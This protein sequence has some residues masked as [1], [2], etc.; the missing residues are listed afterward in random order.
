MKNLT[1]RVAKLV[2]T[3]T[4]S[5]W[6]QIHTFFPDDL[7]KRHKRGILLAVLSFSGAGE[8]VEAMAFGR[9][10]LSR[11]HEEYYGKEEVSVM[12]G[13]VQAVE[14]V[15][16]EFSG[17][18]R[19]LEITAGVILGDI[20]YLAIFGP[21]QV[22]VKRENT[23]Q[24][25]LVGSGEKTENASGFIKTQDIIILGTGSFFDLLPQGVL[26]AALDG[27]GPEQIAETLAPEVVGREQTAMVASLIGRIEEELPIG[28]ELPKEE[29]QEFP[30]PEE[31]LVV[32]KPSYGEKLRE[33]LR[34]MRVKLP[35]ID[36]KKFSSYFP[37]R[38]NAVSGEES[39]YLRR[40][41]KEVKTRK[42]IF[43]VA[44]ILVFLLIS[45]VIFGGRKKEDSG[46]QVQYS[47]L[48][49]EVNS[50]LE[51][52]QSLISLNPARAKELLLE[53]KEKFKQLEG[54]K[55]QNSQTE[56]LGKK[57]EEG[58]ELLSKEQVPTEVPIYLDL[59]LIKENTRGNKLSLHDNFLVVLDSTDNRVLGINL[60]KKS[61]EILAGGDV[62]AGAT[63]TAN[64]GD[65]VYVLVK[66]GIKKIGTKSKN[67]QLVIKSDPEWGRIIALGSFS[68][69]LYLLDAGKGTIWY[70]RPTGA[71]FSQKQKWF[72][73]PADITGVT[74]M[75]IDGSIWLLR[76]DGKIQK[77]SY[78]APLD[79]IVRGLDQALSGSTLIYV[80]E[81]TKNMYILDKGNK[82]TVILGKSGEYVSQY[83][84]GGLASISDFA[85]S[86]KLKK[87][88]LLQENKIFTIDLK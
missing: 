77:F 75:K 81:E 6:S 4:S 38:R 52:G 58:L 88:F 71:G 34:G 1:A 33:F 48:L 12:N 26:R 63:L 18:G 51:E 50:R 49:A 17:D 39:I 10:I 72:K 45:S 59:N 60:E 86:E 57:L 41:E 9:E 44:L 5:S 25:V 42:T 84:W 21:G 43:T 14:K 27:D 40:S 47:Q 73:Q 28:G 61:G 56:D 16:Q 65:W 30:Q 80:D 20:F 78:G 87:I 31:S 83:R 66:E 79:Y 76:D 36:L 74:D 53:A 85:V 82:R 69:N 67:I 15:S 19:R 22:W 55:I 7:E 8:G 35:S 64:D 37:R 23:I 11:L 13:L 3:P 62:V 70:Y 46:K 68:G 54:L 24:K 32:S 29:I 2:G